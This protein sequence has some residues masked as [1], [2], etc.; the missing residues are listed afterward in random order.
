M[1]KN[2]KHSG[3]TLIELLVVIAIIGLLMALLFPAISKAIDTGN[4]NKAR[5]EAMQ[6]ASAIDMFWNDEQ[7]LPVAD[8][9]QRLT[10]AQENDATYFTEAVSKEIIQVLI[11]ENSTINPR[12]KVYLPISTKDVDGTYLDPWESQYY[13]KLDRDYNHKISYGSVTGKHG[14]RAVVVSAGKD[15]NITTL[16]DNVANVKFE[17]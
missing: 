10:E 11:G 4:R 13:I 1:K 16:D 17:D 5:G 2:K 7:R 12:G 8:N 3:F 15:R 9:R 14:V 6:I